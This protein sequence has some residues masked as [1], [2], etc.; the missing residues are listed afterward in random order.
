MQQNRESAQDNNQTQEPAQ[1]SGPA[2]SN[3]AVSP[4]Y[5]ESEQGIQGRTDGGQTRNSRDGSNGQ[6]ENQAPEQITMNQSY[7]PPS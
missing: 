1:T 5:M 2:V 7:Q 4:P 6:E 3:V